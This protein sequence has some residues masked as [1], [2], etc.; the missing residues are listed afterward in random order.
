MNKTYNSKI[1]KSFKKLEFWLNNNGYSGFDPFDLIGENWVKILFGTKNNFFGK[2][3]WILW[4]ITDKYPVFFRKILM[5]KQKINAKGMGLIAHSFLLMYENTNNSHYL[6]K[7]E[8]IL[9]W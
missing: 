4:S 3:R 5:V 8:D 9:N 1:N 6:E 7:A 2:C